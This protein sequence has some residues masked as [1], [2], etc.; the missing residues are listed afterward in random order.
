MRTARFPSVFYIS[1]SVRLRSCVLSLSWLYPVSFFSPRV[2]SLKIYVS[3]C[4]PGSSSYCFHTLTLSIQSSDP[5]RSL[6]LVLSAFAHIPPPPTYSSRRPPT[7]S[8]PW[9]SHVATQGHGTQ[10]V[11]TQS[12]TIAADSTH[13]DNKPNHNTPLFANLP[14]LPPCSTISPRFAQFSVQASS[15]SFVAFS[16]QIRCRGAKAAFCLCHLDEWTQTRSPLLFC[17]CAWVSSGGFS[18]LLCCA[19]V[20]ACLCFLAEAASQPL[21]Q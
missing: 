15:P 8:Q 19:V 5:S 7:A 6:A 12:Q 9:A 20:I 11:A 4:Y 18:C 2:I 17:G 13:H 16:V 10:A 21:R 14:C 3:L 1:L